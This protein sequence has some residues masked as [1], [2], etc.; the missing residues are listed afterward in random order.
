VDQ[1]ELARQLGLR[2]D[3]SDE[4]AKA[5]R[6]EAEGRKAALLEALAAKCGALL[7]LEALRG[8]GGGGEVG[9]GAG[10]GAGAGVCCG[11][12]GAAA[13]RW[14]LGLAVVGAGVCCGG[15]GA[16]AAARWALGLAVVVCG[17][18]GRW[19]CWVGWG[20]GAGAGVPAA[21]GAGCCARS[22]WRP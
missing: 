14:A 5:G 6:K 21:G 2:S 20:G 8:G 17:L 10:G 4:A 18:R 7:D 3:D 1:G 9:A 11:G 22:G 16:A 15:A 19:W 12:A 13:A